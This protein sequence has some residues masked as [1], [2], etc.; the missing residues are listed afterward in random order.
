MVNE[1]TSRL[2]PRQTV[3]YDIGEEAN[4]YV[5]WAFSRLRYISS[6]IREMIKQDGNWLDLVQE[7]YAAGSFPGSS[8]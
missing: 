6:T 3:F 5:K 1:Q 7:L 4:Q 8:I 2:N